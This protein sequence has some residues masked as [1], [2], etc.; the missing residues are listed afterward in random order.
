MSFQNSYGPDGSININVIPSFGHIV[1][2]PEQTKA[3][4]VH[5][6]LFLDCWNWKM[7]SSQRSL[8]TKTRWLRPQQVCF[9]QLSGSCGGPRWPATHPWVCGKIQI[10][11]KTRFLI[12]YP[13][14]FIHSW[15]ICIYIFVIGEKN[16][17][18][19]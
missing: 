7:E 18:P 13:L 1:N 16:S 2:V 12:C 5:F 10:E 8:E 9:F 17:S 11:Q 4:T 19:E 6:L 14:Y 15:S 3:V